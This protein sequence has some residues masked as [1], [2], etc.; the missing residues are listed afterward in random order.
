ML[1]RGVAAGRGAPG[2]R[3]V[4]ASAAGATGGSALRGPGFGPGFG[5]GLPS[6][7]DLASVGTRTCAGAFTSAAAAG[8]AGSTTVVSA[9][10]GFGTALTAGLSAGAARSA[11]G[12]SVRGSAGAGAAFLAPRFFAGGFFSNSSAS[13][14]TTGASIVEDADRTNSPIV[15]SLSSTTLLVTPSSFASS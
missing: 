12:F 10:A 3:V 15:F 7:A 13:R 8:A 6:G 5:P 1:G 4:P 2:A 14:R 9:G 11:A